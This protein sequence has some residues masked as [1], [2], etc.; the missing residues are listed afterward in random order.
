MGARTSWLTG[1][2]ALVLG[3][4][5]V[6]LIAVVALPRGGEPES[7]GGGQEQGAA[8]V[9]GEGSAPDATDSASDEAD[10]RG[11]DP[12]SEASPPGGS[13]EGDDPRSEASPPDGS[14]EGD[15]V[16]EADWDPGSLAPVPVDP[17]VVNDPIDLDDTGD[18]GTGLTMEV[19][20]IESVD[21]EATDRFEVAGPALQIHLQAT[22]NTDDLIT[23]ARTQVEVSYGE[24]RIP[25]LELSGPGVTAFPTSLAAGERARATVVFRVPVDQRD[26]VQILVNHGTDAP[27]IVFEGAAT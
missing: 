16:A 3:A 21:G 7:A 1:R 9:P 23:L 26:Q 12:R 8:D 4:L 19:L 10:G 11:D 5:A 22:N 18:F 6:A 24:D 17:V 14:A 20:R 27:T 25:G 13:T 15:D 2:R